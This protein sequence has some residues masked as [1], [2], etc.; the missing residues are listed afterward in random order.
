[1]ATAMK[2]KDVQLPTASDIMITR[3]EAFAPETEIAAAVETLLGRGY[4]GAPVVDAQ[5]RSVADSDRTDVGRNYATRPEIAAALDGERSTGTRWSETLDTNLVYVSV[6]VASD[7]EVHGAVRITLPSQAVE[8]RV[9]E[10]ALRAA[11]AAGACAGGGG[12]CD[13]VGVR[14]GGAFIAG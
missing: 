3:V 13:E 9:R 10:E 12:G 4:S 1:M 6:P 8:K 2:T 5:G 14:R 11:R 7:G